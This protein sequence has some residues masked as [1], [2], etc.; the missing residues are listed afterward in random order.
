MEEISVILEDIKHEIPYNNPIEHVPTNR[1]KTEFTLRWTGDLEGIGFFGEPF[2]APIKE[3]HP[4]NSKLEV[5]VGY[6]PI[7]DAC[8]VELIK[9]CDVPTLHCVAVVRRD[10]YN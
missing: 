10:V 4:D 3:P 1:L 6:E 2:V 8:D 5:I 7:P 9:I